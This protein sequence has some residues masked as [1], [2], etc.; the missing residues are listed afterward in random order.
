MR[1]ESSFSSIRQL[2]AGRQRR[3]EGQGTGTE[4]GGGRKR[5]GERARGDDGRPCVPARISGLRRMFLSLRRL[6]LVPPFTGIVERAIGCVPAANEPTRSREERL[7]KA[8]AEC[9]GRVKR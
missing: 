4:R 1:Q 6:D 2:T 3:E 8:T 5:A 9:L 7:Y